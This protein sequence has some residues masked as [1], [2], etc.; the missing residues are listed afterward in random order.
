MSGPAPLERGQY[1]HLYDRG[2]D[3]QNVFI[4]DENYA[5]FLKLY[6]HHLYPVVETYAYCLLRNHFHLL[7][8]VREEPLADLTGSGKP[9]RSEERH[10]LSGFPQ[11][12]RSEKQS[13]RSIAQSRPPSQAFSNFFNAYAKAVN[14]RYGR[15]GSLFERPFERILV[16]SAA[17]FCWLVV[18]IHR[19][20]EK[21]RF[22]ADFRDWPYSS[23]HSLLSAQATRLKREAVIDWFGGPAGL[24][25]YHDR[26]GEERYIAPLVENDFD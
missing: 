23:Y 7:I 24:I 16:T 20:P 18:Y 22:V 25:A 26:G 14:K 5:Y 10:D 4:D 12:D 19:N 8:R 13:S 6:A 11:P 1:Y 15:T 9:V 21:H 3:G 17:Y 2:I